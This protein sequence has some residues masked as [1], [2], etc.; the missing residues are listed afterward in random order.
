MRSWWISARPGDHAALAGGQQQRLVAVDAREMPMFARV[1]KGALEPGAPVQS[2]RFPPSRHNAC[3]GWSAGVAHLALDRADRAPEPL[4]CRP[5]MCRGRPSTPTVGSGAGSDG[6]VRLFDAASSACSADSGDGRSQRFVYRPRR[7]AVLG[8][9]EG[10]LTLWKPESDVVALMND[11]PVPRTCHFSADD[12]SLVVQYGTDAEVWALSGPIRGGYSTPT[13]RP[14]AV[15]PHTS[16][17]SSSRWC[18]SAPMVGPMA[19]CSTQKTF[20]GCC[21]R[22]HPPAVL[23]EGEPS[24]LKRWCACVVLWSH[25]RGLR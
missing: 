6:V 20:M 21:G 7:N 8:T 1:A 23:P 5:T 17:Q 2:L 11:G 22:P 15:A 25:A 13:R 14:A 4:P 16:M 19:G 10:T 12:Q 24:D 18:R 3:A 9:A